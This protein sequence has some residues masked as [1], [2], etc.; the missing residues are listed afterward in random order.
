MIP[1]SK[2]DVIINNCSVGVG[3]TCI[4]PCPLGGGGVWGDAPPGNLH[5]LRLLLGVGKTCIEPRPLGGGGGG[6]MPPPGN[7][8]ALRLLLGLQN[9]WKLATNELLSI[10]KNV[11]F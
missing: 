6:V 9:G 10:K 3:K 1:L 11:N 2:Y 4:E 5:A 7:L 8:H